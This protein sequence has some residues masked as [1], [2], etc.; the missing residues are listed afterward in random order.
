MKARWRNVYERIDGR[1]VQIDVM[2]IK[3]T[4]RHKRGPDCWC[5][6][7]AEKETDQAPMYGHFAA[8][9]R[10]LVETQGVN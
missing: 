8:D 7:S 2:P 5:K 6:P 3:D 4:R 9:G 1:L 10:H